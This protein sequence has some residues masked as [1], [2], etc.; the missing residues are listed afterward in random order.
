[1]LTEEQWRRFDDP[2]H[3]FMQLAGGVSPRKLRL[4][5]VA[6]AR[7]VFARLSPLL[8]SGGIA[9]AVAERFAEGDADADELRRAHEPALDDADRDMGSQVP[10]PAVADA[11]CHARWACA[12]CCDPAA[13]TAADFAASAAASSAY[14]AA[15]AAGRPAAPAR[16]AEKA[17]QADL[18]REIV[19][20]FVVP[21]ADAV[22]AWNGGAVPHIAAAVYRDQAFERLPVLADALEDA[23]CADAALLAHLRGPGPHLRGCWALDLARGVE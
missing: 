16:A 6:C 5:A 15:T 20:P 2:V 11:R 22:L 3:Q 13:A 18:L 4:F 14:H 10:S 1:M 8:N 23:G 9:V 17:V 21:L 7:R 19:N 12:H